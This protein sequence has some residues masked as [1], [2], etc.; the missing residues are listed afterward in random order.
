MK[1]F[2]TMILMCISVSACSDGF[3]FGNDEY[4]PGVVGMASV[5]DFMR[6]KSIY[7][8]GEVKTM[9]AL[10]P[11]TMLQVANSGT[12]N[13]SSGYNYSKILEVTSNTGIGTFLLNLTFTNP[14]HSYNLAKSYVIS[15]Q[16]ETEGGYGSPRIYII[17]PQEQFSAFRLRNTPDSQGNFLYIEKNDGQF[18][19]FSLSVISLSEDFGAVYYEDSPWITA[20]P[21]ATSID[22]E[23]VIE[24]KNVVVPI[25]GRTILSG[26][27]WHTAT[28]Q[29]SWV[30]YGGGFANASYRKMPDGRIEIKGLVKNGT[31]NTSI[32]TLPAGYR[33]SESRIF[34]AVQGNNGVVRLN[35]ASGGD[36]YTA[37]ATSNA[38][39]SIE[40][41]FYP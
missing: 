41:S 29:N 27:S 32:F 3:I 17:G 7:T 13:A 34:T 10:P 21:L 1:Y 18:C 25:D 15:V 23:V 24:D 33:P 26:E 2:L 19:T 30:N 12:D 5:G 14:S 40:A 16:K 35:V 36:V 39:Q 9:E 11:G 4:F 31:L 20:P 22:R 28:L 8:G 37:G 38:F 6:V